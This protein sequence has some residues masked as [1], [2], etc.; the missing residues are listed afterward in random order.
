MDPVGLWAVARAS[1]LEG[2]FVEC[3]VNRRFAQKRSR[4]CISIWNR[5]PPEG[6]SNPLLLGPSSSACVC[7]SWWLRLLRL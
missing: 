7:A 3:E 2:D 1:R 5:S 4:I 6:C